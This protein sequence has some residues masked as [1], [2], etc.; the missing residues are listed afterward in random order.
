MLESILNLTPEQKRRVEEEIGPVRSVADF[1]SNLLEATKEIPLKEKLVKLLPWA[2]KGGHI[3]GEV[4]PL[5]KVLVKLVDEVAEEKDPE[6]LGL[7]ACSLAYERAAALALAQQG[8]PGYRVPFEHSLQSAREGLKKLKVGVNL[9]GFSLAAPLA[10]PFVWQADE[11]LSFVVRNSGYAESEWRRIQLRVHDQFRADLVDVLS[12]GESATRFAPFTRRLSLG[13]NAAAYAAIN[14]HIERQRWLFEDRPVLNIE[15]F[16][17]DDVYV[18]T[19]CGKLQWKDFPNRDESKHTTSDEKFDPFSEHF[20]GRHPLLETVLEYLRDPGFNDAI[21]V[22]GPPGCGKSSFTLRLANTLRREGLR[23]LRI[24]LK[25]LDLKKNL[26]EALAQIVLQPEED[27]DPAL[28]HLPRCSDP[29]LNDTI[30]QERTKFGDAEICPYVLILDGWDEISV[31]VNEGFEI[32]VHRMLKNVRE[33]FLR[34]RA[35]KVRVLLTGR[36]SH[37]VERSQFLRDDTPVLTLREYTAN[38]LESYVANV[39]SAVNHCTLPAGAEAWPDVDWDNLKRDLEYYRTDQGNLDIL[40]LPLLAHLGL[41]LLAQWKAGPKELLL[42]RTALYRHLL[43][44]TCVKS[45]KASSDADDLL[46]QARIRGFE[47]RRMLQQTAVAITAYGNES[48]PFRELQLRL[49]KSR[50]KTMEEAESAGKERPLT[51][52]MISFYFKGGREHLGCEFLHK[53]F[54]EYLYAEAIL[55]ALKDYG[56]KEFSSPAR[57]EP[58]WQDFQDSDPRRRFSRDLSQILCPYRLSAEIRSHVASLL[59]WEIERSRGKGEE[60]QLGQSVD[61]LTF[62]K[63]EMIQDGLEDLW[64]WWCEGVHLRPQPH[65][66]DSDNLLYRAAFV[67]ELLDYSLPRDRGPDALEWWPGRLVNSDANV[68]DALCRL[69]VWMHAA[70]LQ[71]RGWNGVL[72]SEWELEGTVDSRRHPHESQFKRSEEVF[73]LFRPSGQSTGYFQ[74]YCSRIN[75]AGKRTE[76]FP[77]L[78]DLRCVDLR[79]ADLSGVHLTGT[80]FRGAIL[81]EANLSGADLSG[82]DL[83]R[84]DLRGANLCRARL[85]STD[86]REANLGMGDLCGADLRGADLRGADL[87]MA[88]LTDANLSATHL[89]NDNLVGTLGLTKEQIASAYH[90]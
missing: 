29:F 15:P 83:R 56:R 6:T 8:E 77:A 28:A 17:L 53:S 34:P 86:F 71:V 24:R 21:V 46:G 68:G 26:S 33:Q 9:S 60:H 78:V 59:T 80:D 45:G 48:I 74:N 18:D 58:Y 36:P 50:R 89:G 63:W 73:V 2:A 72:A 54:R 85:V 55:E 61:S 64:D 81:R 70:I 27:E 3:V 38:Q 57:R 37:A 76:P 75:A 35:V 20:G 31:A 42:N 25:F 39:E 7:L 19:D 66:D 62:A 12:H 51:S 88:R 32:E 14:A 67:N 16:A 47:L 79:G 52:L 82:A 30:F 23:P 5:A 43:D 11:S 40:G 90:D 44:L 84:A 41:K 4:T 10:H 22:Q 1:C 87:R 65:R 13:E 69:N 49:K